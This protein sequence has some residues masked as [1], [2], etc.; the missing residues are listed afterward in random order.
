MKNIP[1]R[2][3]VLLAVVASTVLAR[4]VN[5]EYLTFNVDGNPVVI[6][7]AEHP[8]ITFTDNTLHIKTEKETIDI[9]VS[10]SVS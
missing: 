6:A 4:A 1:K 5:V 2:F 10:T 9:P 3:L 8:V 7:L